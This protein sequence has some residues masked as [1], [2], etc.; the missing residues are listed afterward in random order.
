[1]PPNKVLK[2][3]T[4][5]TLTVLLSCSHHGLKTEQ[6]KGEVPVNSELRVFTGIPIVGDYDKDADLDFVIR[7]EDNDTV[8]K[9]R[10]HEDI[11]ITNR[12]LIY[13]IRRWINEM[14]DWEMLRVSGS[15]K[16]D[17]RGKNI[18]YGS[19]NLDTITFLDDE[20]EFTESYDT[21]PSDALY[22][23]MAAGVAFI[24]VSFGR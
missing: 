22:Y 20:N 14:E 4:V 1:M 2:A 10:V 21:N 23:I 15:Y 3:I 8:L 7:V 13:K 9:I 24:M 18:E 17:Y 19:L 11:F 16:V 12:N 5:F 6:R